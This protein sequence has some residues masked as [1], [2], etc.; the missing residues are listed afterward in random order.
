MIAPMELDGVTYTKDEIV[1]V[2]LRVI[3]MRDIALE[4]A[5]FTYAMILSANIALLQHLH[6]NT[7]E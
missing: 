4:Q 6:D 2:R 5:S 1:G 7:S 3:I